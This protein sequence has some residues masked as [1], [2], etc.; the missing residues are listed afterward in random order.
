[1][2]VGGTADTLFLHFGFTCAKRSG[3]DD[4][5]QF[6]QQVWTAEQPVQPGPDWCNGLHTTRRLTCIES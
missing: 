2:S 4:S 5:L 3:A 6:S 1:M